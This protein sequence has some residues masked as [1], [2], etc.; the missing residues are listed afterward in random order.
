MQLTFM[1]FQGV[2]VTCGN[3]CTIASMEIA[4]ICPTIYMYSQADGLSLKF[5]SLVPPQ[6]AI[7][8]AILLG[9]CFCTCV[10]QSFLV[11]P[12]CSIDSNTF[13]LTQRCDTNMLKCMNIIRISLK[14][15][16]TSVQKFH[17]IFLKIS[18]YTDV[19]Q[20]IVSQQHSSQGPHTQYT[21][22]NPGTRSIISMAR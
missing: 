15:L 4:C 16:P 1:H 10:S 14:F 13:I 11:L 9:S 6:L 8:C 5:L 20:K 12:Y 19:L 7:V 17:Y 2:S 18:S 3:E 22:S 21:A